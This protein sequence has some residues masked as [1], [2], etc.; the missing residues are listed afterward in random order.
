MKHR[1]Q[2]AAA[3]LV[4]MLVALVALGLVTRATDRAERAGWERG[5]NQGTADTLR[6]HDTIQLDQ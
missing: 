5:Y 1:A 3:M 6:D 4:A 2:G